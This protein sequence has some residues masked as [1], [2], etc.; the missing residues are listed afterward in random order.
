MG[1]W[2]SGP[3]D[4]SPL[5]EDPWDPQSNHLTCLR[6]SFP[7]CRMGTVNWTYLT[8]GVRLPASLCKVLQDPGAKGTL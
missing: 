7:I 5:S 8:G 3:Q 1:K 2:E 4:P 6:F